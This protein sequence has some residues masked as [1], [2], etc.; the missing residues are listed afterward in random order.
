M[1][2]LHISAGNKCLREYRKTGGLGVVN[3][4]V[5]CGVCFFALRLAAI[6]VCLCELRFALQEKSRICLGNANILP[7]T[8][9]FF[10]WG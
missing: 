2:I 8:Y 4:C 7:I 10:D 3:V 6:V 1:R 5:V 9:M